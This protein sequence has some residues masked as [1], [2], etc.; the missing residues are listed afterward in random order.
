[1]RRWLPSADPTRQDVY[2]SVSNAIGTKEGSYRNAPGFQ[3][4]GSAASSPGTTL[5]NYRFALPSGATTT[6]TA[7]TTK[8]YV[9]L[10][11]DRS[12]GG[13][14]TNTAT[15]WSGAQY[16]NCTI[17]TNG[18]DAPQVRDATGSSAFA[19]L[20]GTPPTTAKYVVTQAN[21]VLFFNTNTGGQYWAAS[22]VGN[23]ANYTTGEAASGPINHRPGGITA[24]AAFG[25]NEVIVWKASSFYR[26]RYV[27]GAVKWTVE[28]ISDKFGAAGPGS[29]CVCGTA[30]LVMDSKGA[31]I[32]DG[33][34][35]HPI[36]DGIGPYFYQNSMDPVSAQYFRQQDSAWF[37]VAAQRVITYNLKTG[38]WGNHI[39]RQNSGDITGS[40]RMVVGDTY[41]NEMAAQ[42][43]DAGLSS[44][45][46]TGYPF[47]EAGGNLNNALD[48]SVTTGWIGALDV[49]T[50]A[51]RLKPVFRAPQGETSE[52]FGK[53]AYSTLSLVIVSADD[54]EDGGTSGSTINASS[55][56]RFDF[57]NSAPWQKFQVTFTNTP[58]ELLDL[59]VTQAKK[60][61]V[62]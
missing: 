17:M 44:P 41:T 49:N 5:N 39:P 6:I 23:H 7:T 43:V 62:N 54:P 15:H 14:Y 35:P 38:L 3:G 25:T 56:K 22:D 57:T 19:D 32:F 27:G 46:Y 21:A 8:L 9:D 31:Y 47:D 51:S 12:K 16:G 24:A 18:V 33:T 37:H 1:M 48:G 45:I 36:D 42:F 40:I 28:L 50:Y 58:W 11:T 52:G 59:V 26:M 2:T 20:G 55:R 13:G 4:S 60:S 10:F 61:G 30:I 29:V 34:A 53:P